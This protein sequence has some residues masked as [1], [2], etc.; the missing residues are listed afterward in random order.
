MAVVQRLQDLSEDPGGLLLGEELVLDDAVEEFAA[1]TGLGDQVDI[2]LVLEVLEELQH[3]RVVQLLQN[4]DLL[5]EPIHVLDLLLSDLL[6]RP[7]LLGLPMLA[8]RHHSVSPRPQRL[9]RNLIHLLYPPRV[10]LDHGL[11]LNNP[12]SRF[13]LRLLPSVIFC[14]HFQENYCK[15]NVYQLFII[16]NDKIMFQIIN[17]SQF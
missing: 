5:L 15:F 1:T 16:I 13:Q 10:F 14:I 12:S 4:R 17:Y 7:L 9:L 2:L 11:L 6:D 3:V 8:Q